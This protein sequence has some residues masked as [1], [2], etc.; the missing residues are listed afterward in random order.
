MA[1]LIVEMAQ[2]IYPHKTSKIVE[3]QI[4]A[5][6]SKAPCYGAKRLNPNIS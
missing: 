4:I 6:R 2:I 1:L 3:Q 5:Y